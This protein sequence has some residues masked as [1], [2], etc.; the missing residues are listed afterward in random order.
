MEIIV[1][2]KETYKHIK[3]I[4]DKRRTRCAECGG[5]GLCEH[6]K[7]KET[8]FFCHGSAYCIHNIQKRVCL[9][10][11]GSHFCIHKNR[12]HRCKICGGSELCKSKFCNTLGNKHYKG[13]CLKCTVELFPNM[14][15]RSN[16]K[17]KELSVIRNIQNRFVNITMLV[18]KVVGFSRKRPDIT[19]DLGAQ[20]IVVE[21]DEEQ[22]RT[23]K[24]EGTRI[25]QLSKDFGFRP[26]VFIRFNPDSYTNENGLFIKSCWSKSKDGFELNDEKE[27]YSRIHDLLSTIQYWIDNTLDIRI[28]VIKKFYDHCPLPYECSPTT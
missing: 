7:L 18:D 15:R 6:L 16:L 12:K 2:K 28:T 21:I 19:I 14:K 8:C 4:H 17:S 3:C 13:Y 26:V 27:W 1:K 24:Q 20:V 9:A 25:L 10:C 22:H 5:S 11:D 23:Y